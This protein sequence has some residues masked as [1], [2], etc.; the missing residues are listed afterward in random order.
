MAGSKLG[1]V[2]AISRMKR[3]HMKTEWLV[4]LD[5]WGH[6]RAL[7]DNCRGQDLIEYAL[8]A[9]L[10]AAS[11]VTMFPAIADSFTTIMSKTNSVL[12]VAGS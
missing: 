1:W 4:C 11:V 12:V 10:I 9:G 6:L 8:L 5:L 3:L 7:R 2:R